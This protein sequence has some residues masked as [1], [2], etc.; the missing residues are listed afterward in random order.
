MY[1]VT[2]EYTSG[3][4]SVMAPSPL[5]RSPGVFCERNSTL[6]LSSLSILLEKGPS[7]RREVYSAAELRV[8]MSR[9]LALSALTLV[10]VAILLIENGD[11]GSIRDWYVICECP[12]TMIQYE[13]LDIKAT[14]S[15][16]PWSLNRSG[17][18]VL[19]SHIGAATIPALVRW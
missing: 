6:F 2:D 5:S 14:H 15:S 12:Q 11:C 8:K 9:F 3:R 18:G 13:L 7:L 10:L 19:R 1:R 17:Q 4:Q 16:G